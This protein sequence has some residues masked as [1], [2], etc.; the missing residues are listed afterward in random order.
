MMR[1]SLPSSLTRVLSASTPIPSGLSGEVANSS[2]GSGGDKALLRRDRLPIMA[3]GCSRPR[4]VSGDELT[5]PESDPELSA[6]EL[7]R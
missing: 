4:E 2:E 6:S 3:A 7:L 5:E 1:A